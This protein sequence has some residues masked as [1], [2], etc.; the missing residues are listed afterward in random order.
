MVDNAPTDRQKNK[1][2]KCGAANKKGQGKGHQRPKDNTTCGAKH[3]E[4]SNSLVPRL[5]RAEAKSGEKNAR[6]GEKQE[7]RGGAGTQ[8][9]EAKSDQEQLSATA[10]PYNCGE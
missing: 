4:V 2:R 9:P 10:S 6:T 5:G 3:E 7:V 1:N 8:A